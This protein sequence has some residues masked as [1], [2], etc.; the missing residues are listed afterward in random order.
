M[1]DKGIVLAPVSSRIFARLFDLFLFLAVLVISFWTLENNLNDHPVLVNLVVNLIA[2]IFFL[3]YFVFIPYFFANQTLGKKLWSIKIFFS[4]KPKGWILFVKLFFREFYIMFAPIFLTWLFYGLY[5]LLIKFFLGRSILQIDFLTRTS[6][7]FLLWWIF[8]FLFVK[9]EP[10][11]QL[12]YDRWLGVLVVKS[13]G[14][15]LIMVKKKLIVQKKKQIDLSF[16]V[17]EFEKMDFFLNSEQKKAV[18]TAKDFNLRIIAGPGT[19]KTTVLINRIIFFLKKHHYLSH[20]ILVLTF[21]RKACQHIKKRIEKS[22]V[23]NSLTSWSVFTYHGFCYWFLTVIKRQRITVLDQSDQKQVIKHLLAQDQKQTQKKIDKTLIKEVLET[24]NVLQQ[25]MVN[26]FSTFEQKEFES[27]FFSGLDLTKKKQLWKLY[28]NYLLYKKKEQLFDFSDL[29]TKTYQV[30]QE[31]KKLLRQL[32]QRFLHLAV[33]EFQD[34]NFLQYALINLISGSGKLI[35]TTVVGDPDQTIYG[36]RGSNIDFIL[37]FHND[38][39]NL[40]TVKLITNYRSQKNIV[41]LANHLITKNKKRITKKITAVEKVMDKIVLFSGA[42]NFQSAHFIVKEIE[43]KVSSGV[44]HKNIAVLYRANYLSGILE[45]LLLPKN[46][47]YHIFKGQEFF[48]RKEIK[49]LL[50]LLIVLVEPKDVYLQI[51]L[52]W[53]KGIGEKIIFKIQKEAASVNKTIFQYLLANQPSFLVKSWKEI[54]Y[55]LN[56]IQGLQQK[57]SEIQSL[58][59]L[60]QELFTKIYQPILSNNLD[61]EQR[62][63][64]VDVLIQQVVDGFEKTNLDLSIQDKISKFLSHSQLFAAS[65]ISFEAESVQLMTIHNAK[66]LEFDY[67][68]IFD[69]SGNNFPNQDRLNIDLEEERR[70]FFVAITRAKKGVFITTNSYNPSVFIEEI[71]NCSAVKQWR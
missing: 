29:L 14:R 67:V 15:E 12:F 58:K 34:V 1:K 42:S 44:R 55:F 7:V 8:L 26:D 37:N 53:I 49:D 59:V 56:V 60:L 21:S 27:D 3:I 11:H 35:K 70:L 25:E 13:T 50:L 68:F 47:P 45:T 43:R 51:V 5:V 20:Q 6:V 17:N 23:A 2:F 63:K 33:D 65:E 28:E 64:N 62:L 16:G 24:I 66:G 31:D 36:W 40:Q 32:Q 61:Y 38:F 10:K 46:I 19:G 69:V 9:I 30:L 71:A 54:E 22:V 52:T 4:L 39:S 57:L 18:F 48:K 41:S